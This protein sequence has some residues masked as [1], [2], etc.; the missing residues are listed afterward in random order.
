[1]H[2]LSLGIS[3]STGTTG[4]F[5]RLELGKRHLIVRFL[6]SFSAVY[7]VARETTS[8]VIGEN[9]VHSNIGNPSMIP[10]QIRPR[11]GGNPAYPFFLRPNALD[12]VLFW[13]LKRLRFYFSWG[14]HEL[15]TSLLFIPTGT[16]QFAYNPTAGCLAHEG[17][18]PKLHSSDARHGLTEASLLGGAPTGAK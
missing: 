17:S 7:Q 5:P 8:T 13:E 9:P 11:F 4:L 1:M 3:L 16:K 6:P 18:C 14:W 10:S 15:E 2:V 12:F